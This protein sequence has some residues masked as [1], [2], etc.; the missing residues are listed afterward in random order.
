MPRS[1][2]R[3]Q[4]FLDLSN[5]YHG[6]KAQFPWG[7]GKYDVE[8]LG[9]QVT[10]PRNLIGLSI[11]DALKDP[12]ME[13]KGAR[14]QQRFHLTIQRLSCPSFPIVLIT[15]P[16][17]YTRFFPEVPPV[18]KGIDARIVQDMIVGAFDSC[19]DVGVLLSGD[20]DFEDVV[21]FLSSG[22][23][24]IDLETYYPM[25]R[26]HLAELTKSCFSKA[27]VIDKRFYQ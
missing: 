7:G 27:I 21:R 17:A 11:Y 25:S 15:R 1:Q 13:P 20:R 26:R 3:V 23:F 22:R 5:M 18:E 14:L 16:L 12:K 8:K 10:G 2:K 19:Y 24:S 6:L 4:I 9:R